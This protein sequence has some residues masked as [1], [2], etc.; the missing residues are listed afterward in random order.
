MPTRKRQECAQKYRGFCQRYKTKK[1]PASKKSHWG[2]KL[3]AGFTLK[4]RHP[5][6]PCQI[7][8]TPEKTAVVEQF[9][10]ANQGFERSVRLMGFFNPVGDVL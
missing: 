8:P 1:K 5:P 3:P 6:H 4:S 10:E 9:I 2:N 7:S